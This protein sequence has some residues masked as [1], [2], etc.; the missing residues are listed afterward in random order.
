M[1]LSLRLDGSLERKLNRHATLVGV[2]KS[3]L[4][5]TLILDYLEK[6]SG[7]RT[8]W[9]LGEKYFGREGSGKGNLSAERKVILKEKLH[10]KKN[11]HRFGTVD[12][13]V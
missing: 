2:P 11:R 5:R 1:A 9:E 7:A 4:V 12:R 10:A 6:D 13:A 3:E 8:P